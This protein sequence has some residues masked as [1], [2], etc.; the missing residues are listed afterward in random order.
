[1]I[2]PLVHEADPEIQLPVAE[3][4]GRDLPVL[5]TS[6]VTCLGPRLVVAAVSLL[7]EIEAAAE[8]VTAIGT[9]TETETEIE[10][11]IE[12]EIL[13]A[14]AMM[15]GLVAGAVHEVAGE[16]EA[17]T[18]IG[19]EREAEVPMSEKTGAFEIDLA[20]GIV[21]RIRIGNAKEAAVERRT[22]IGTERG[23]GVVLRVVD[24]NLEGSRSLWD[25][26]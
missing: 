16:T 26:R 22:G 20:R 6:T 12:I 13:D 19:I 23:R 9:E 8:I 18:E 4:E 17:E 11:E 2:A 25:M 7:S 21:R 15:T 14:I 3:A 1:M 24:G 10:I 5:S